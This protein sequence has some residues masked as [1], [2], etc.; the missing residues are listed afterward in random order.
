VK[1]APA[2]LLLIA[3]TALVGW[4]LTLLPSPAQANAD[5]ELLD[6]IDY[7]AGLLCRLLDRATDLLRGL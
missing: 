4:L 5:V 3:G 6:W 7:A 2:I 1:P